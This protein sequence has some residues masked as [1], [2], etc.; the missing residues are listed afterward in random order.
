MKYDKI[1]KEFI[2][3]CEL[4][5]TSL[6]HCTDCYERSERRARAWFTAYCI[7][8]H[9][10]IWAKYLTYPYWPA[11]LMSADDKMVDVQFFGDHTFE[12]V[13]VDNCLIYSEQH[14][15]K[16]TMDFTDLYEAAQEVNQSLITII[17]YFHF[18][19]TILTQMLVHFV[20]IGM[21]QVHKSSDRSFRWIQI[22]KRWW[23]T[24]F[25]KH[26]ISSGEYVP[27]ASGWRW[28]D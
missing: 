1:V 24:E 8:P 20:R 6:S 28:I 12:T 26:E 25:E 19:H 9:L 21:L 5:L 22:W 23:K 10:L 15:E 18:V 3:S 4:E 11:K 7:P 16:E 17:M 27:E 2:A 14:P 13:P